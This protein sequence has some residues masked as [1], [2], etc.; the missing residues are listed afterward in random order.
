MKVKI[1]EESLITSMLFKDSAEKLG[2][3][4]QVQIFDSRTL[5][6]ELLKCTIQGKGCFYFVQQPITSVE[7]SNETKFNFFTPN[8]VGIFRYIYLDNFKKYKLTL[9]NHVE[10]DFLGDDYKTNDAVEKIEWNSKMAYEMIQNAILATIFGY[11]M[12]EALVNQSIPSNYKRVVINQKGAEETHSKDYI[13][14]WYKLTDKLLYVVPEVLG[15]NDIS[16]EEF[17]GHFIQLEDI[18][19][20]LIHSKEKEFDLYSV[21]F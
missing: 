3:F 15:I 11:T 9:V 13:E 20:K 7:F 16:K 6:S 14:R 12:I 8:N 18:R 4:G 19:N 5:K 1:N 2:K 10:K 17:W 21:F